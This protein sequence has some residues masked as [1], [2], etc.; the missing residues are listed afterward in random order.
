MGRHARRTVPHACDLHRPLRVQRPVRR[1]LARGHGPLRRREPCDPRR[2]R[3]SHPG[4]CH[5]RGHE[6]RP[7]PRDQARDRPPRCEVA[8]ARSER[9]RLA[10]AGH[11]VGARPHAHRDGRGLV[12]GLDPPRRDPGRAR[13]LHRDPARRHRPGHRSGAPPGGR[14]RHP[15]HAVH[16][17]PGLLRH[18]R[19][20]GRTR[21]R[22][23]SGIPRPRAR[24]QRQCGAGVVRLPGAVP[25]RRARARRRR[26]G[27][28]RARA[29]RAAVAPLPRRHDRPRRDVR[30][31]GGGARPH[32]RGAG[33]DRRPDQ[34]RAQRRRGHRV[35][36]GGRVTQAAR[37]R[38]PA[39]MDAADQ[40]P[41]DRRAGQ[42]PLRHPR[43]DPPAASA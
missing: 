16:R 31:G 7:E 13:R 11:P 1:L 6:G 23:A 21:G 22:P 38:R 2:A 39:A 17:R 12:R 4:R 41:R 19:C 29:L 33:V 14:G 43:A 40:R 10:R 36:R 9:H 30:L 32:G 24:R 37:H 34:I 15:D 26:E 27:R 5:R 25:Q 3:G 42:D 8:S 28:R 35:P 18:F 20:G